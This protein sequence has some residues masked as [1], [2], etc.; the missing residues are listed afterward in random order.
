[1]KKT[2][3]LEQHKAQ[4]AQFIK[5]NNYEPTAIDFDNTDYLPTSRTIQRRYGGLPNFRKL[6]GLKTTDFTKGKARTKKAKT[7]MDKCLLEETKLFQELLIKY[8]S[9]NV[10]S[11]AKLFL[12]N[13]KT[14]DFKIEKDGKIYLIDV[15]YPNTK[16]SFESC[17]NI[18]NKKYHTNEQSFYTVPVEIILVCLN[19]DVVYEIKRPLKT[20]SISEFRKT[21]LS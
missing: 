21:F 15:F 5:E 11:P 2:I 9:N 17:V 8:G 10:S 12:N 3:S 1:M 13:L 6:I 7:A 19:D 20:I 4:V 16:E 18:K 14:V